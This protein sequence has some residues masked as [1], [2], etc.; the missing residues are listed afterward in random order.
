M[1]SRRGFSF[2][3]LLTVMI[4]IGILAGIALLRYRDFTN[5]ALAARIATDMETV[6][7][8]A[9]NHYSETDTWAAESADGQVPAELVRYLPEGWQFDAGSYSLDWDNLGGVVGVTVRSTRAGL[10]AKLSQRFVRGNP[11]VDLGG[12]VMYVIVAPGIAI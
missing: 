6:R 10:M 8:A 12:D 9:L 2:I 7:L 5:E 1:R 11:F 3:E 4:V